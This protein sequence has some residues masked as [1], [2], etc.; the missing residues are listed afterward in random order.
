M[1]IKLSLAEV[2]EP[3]MENARIVVLENDNTASVKSLVIKAFAENPT[4]KLTDLRDTIKREIPGVSEAEIQAGFGD[5]L[6]ERNPKN[7]LFRGKEKG[8]KIF[9]NASDNPHEWEPD[10]NQ[11]PSASELHAYHV[12]KGHPGKLDDC[13][14]CE[15]ALNN[16]SE[17]GREK[18]SWDTDT[19]PGD[20]LIGVTHSCGTQI[21]INTLGMMDCPKCHPDGF[22]KE[23][24]NA[25]DRNFKVG[26]RVD[27]HDEVGVIV[28][29]IGD[30]QAYKVRFHYGEVTVNEMDIE[31][32]SA[33]FDAE[34][35]GWVDGKVDIREDAT[36]PKCGDSGRLSWSVK[37]GMCVDCATKRNE[38]PVKNAKKLPT[39]LENESEEA[40]VERFMV[41]P[42]ASGEF[43]SDPERKEAGKKE[44]KAAKERRNSETKKCPE[45]GEDL[46]TRTGDWQARI[47]GH[48][49]ARHHESATAAQDMARE[50]LR[51]RKN[52][53]SDLQNAIGEINAGLVRERMNSAFG[54]RWPK[55]VTIKFITPGMVRY[56]D[57]GNNA[58]CD[59]LVRKDVLDRMANSLVGKPVVNENHRKVAPGDYN[60][61]NADGI[62]SKVWYNATDAYYYCDVL[63]WDPDTQ[64]NMQNGYSASCAYTVKDWGEGGTHNNVP[65]DREVKDGEYT[66]MAIVSN[67][68]YEEAH[69]FNSLKGGCMKLMKLLFKD[70]DGRD[71][72]AEL[73]LKTPVELGNGLMPT[74]EELVNTFHLTEAA[75]A[76]V[77][78][79]SKMID[80]GNGVQV[81]LADLKTNY[82]ANGLAAAHKDGKHSGGKVANCGLCNEKKDDPG[83]EEEEKR[84]KEEKE[85]DEAKNQ[86]ENARKAKQDADDKA[87]AARL[88]NAARVRTGALP[89]PHFDSIDDGIA[90]GRAM[91]G[92]HEKLQPMSAAAQ[93]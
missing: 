15:K 47:A 75:K 17:D 60:L 81:K 54:D 67:P 80:V 68:R 71:A 66:H 89:E 73:D 46:E 45:C 53:G 10:H 7:P 57:L 16:A 31:G 65:Y 41:D 24:R 49:F 38:T 30:G 39:P 36:C 69:I 50:I 32:V 48:L 72:S 74:L 13:E 14:K 83:D 23:R 26:D 51:E 37:Y 91:F 62:V 59:V 27:V 85:K 2:Q 87:A 88:E 19:R 5:A 25:Q 55:P 11:P 18:H 12:R 3:I 1:T 90:R 64:R 92:F 4:I 35:G 44:F 8:E 58:E 56:E 22:K 42:F 33:H 86:L 6:R 52:A 28:K 84:K 40:Y 78:D 34:N 79:D 70:K 20:T 93:K 29:V 21:K 82:L 61:G 77:L 76:K 9:E 43:P 63:V